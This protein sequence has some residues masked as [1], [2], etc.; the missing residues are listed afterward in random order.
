MFKQIAIIAAV[1][2]SSSNAMAIEIDWSAVAE[3]AI[4]VTKTVATKTA[5]VSCATSDS[6]KATKEIANMKAD[7]FEQMEK[8]VPPAMG[9][10]EIQ[11]QKIAQQGISMASGATSFILSA[12][13]LVK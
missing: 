4:S 2:F 6:L 1:L 13:C 5:N 9:G 11:S 3:K 12:G 10:N 7:A 8:I